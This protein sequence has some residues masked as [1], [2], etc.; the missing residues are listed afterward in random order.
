MNN[1][2][3]DTE[4][5]FNTMESQQIR[6]SAIEDMVASNNMTAMQCFSQMKNL[7][8]SAW[9]DW[10]VNNTMSDQNEEMACIKLLADIRQ[11]CGDDGQRMQGDL[12]EY[13][14]EL[15][16]K[17]ESVPKDWKPISTASIGD[18]VSVDVSTCDED[19]TNRVFGVISHCQPDGEGGVIWICELD[20]FNFDIQ[21]VKQPISVPK[22]TQVTTDNSKV[23]ADLI[24]ENERLQARVSE[25]EPSPEQC[26]RILQTIANDVCGNIPEEWVISLRMEFGSAWVEASNPDYEAAT[27]PDSADKSLLGQIGDALCVAKG[28]KP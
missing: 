13:I 25:L 6:M 19:S 26:E 14:A 1:I 28:D 3:K 12:V 2:E 20:H 9:K 8:N 24:A 15:Y 5:E 22:G 18:S 16:R 4:S 11:A 10:Q 17:S 23:N 21:T 27:L 7:V